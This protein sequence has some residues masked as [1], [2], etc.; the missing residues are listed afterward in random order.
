V[1]VQ[2]ERGIQKNKVPIHTIILASHKVAFNLDI[3][4]EGTLRDLH[5]DP[6]VFVI[7]ET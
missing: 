4:V 7:Y 6:M 5:P 3:C 1:L 2:H